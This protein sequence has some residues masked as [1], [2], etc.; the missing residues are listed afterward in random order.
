MR[1]VKNAKEVNLKVVRVFLDPFDESH[2][3]GLEIAMRVVLA[4]L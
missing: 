4:V 1:V 2:L 3:F